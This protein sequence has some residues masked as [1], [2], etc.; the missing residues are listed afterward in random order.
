MFRTQ[1]VGMSERRWASRA[2]VQMFIFELKK[3]DSAAE[4][5]S[6]SEDTFSLHS[7]KLAE[8]FKAMEENPA[9]VK[10]ATLKELLDSAREEIRDHQDWQREVLDNLPRVD[11]EEGLTGPLRQAFAKSSKARSELLNEVMNAQERWLD[12][13]TALFDKD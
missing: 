13:Q 6:G 4:V 11:D 3:Y 2:L 5:V 10:P 9:A 1:G 12:L 8:L 7:R